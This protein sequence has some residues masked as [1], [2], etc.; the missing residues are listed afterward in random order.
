VSEPLTGAE[1]AELEALRARVAALEA[2]RAELAARA[3]AAVAAAQR[4]VY[5]L[6]RW[7]VDLNAM[8]ARRS[9]GRVRELARGLRAPVRAV[10]GL[11]RRLLG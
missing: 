5:W 9:A 6:D 10:R 2:E 8:M 3:G 7:H 11:K 4:R 1:R